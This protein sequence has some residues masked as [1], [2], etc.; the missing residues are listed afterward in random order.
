[1]LQPKKTT[2]VYLPEIALRYVAYDSYSYRYDYYNYS[3][4]PER[5]EEFS[6]AVLLKFG[7]QWVLDNSFLVDLYGGIGYGIGDA[8]DDALNYGYCYA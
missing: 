7:K 8:H 2:F 1:M 3:S 5:K 4:S 6:M